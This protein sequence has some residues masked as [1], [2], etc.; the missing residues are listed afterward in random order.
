MVQNKVLNSNQEDQSNNNQQCTNSNT[1]NSQEQPNLD[2]GN[3]NNQTQ[4]DSN[5]GTSTTT[6]G[7]GYKYTVGQVVIPYTKGVAESFKHICGKYGIKVHFKGNTTIIQVL[8]KPKDKDPKDK[9][10][11]SSTASNATT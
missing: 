6:P 8:M 11:G 3:N 2:M 9:K 5:G 7:P 10:S 4:A 1:N